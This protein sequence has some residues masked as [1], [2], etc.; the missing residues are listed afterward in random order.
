MN[1]FLRLELAGRSGDTILLNIDHIVRIHPSWPQGATIVTTDDASL[2]TS[3]S[4]DEIHK[5]M[6]ASN[7]RITVKWIGHVVDEIDPVYEAARADLLP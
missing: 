1:T 7:G 4:L 2:H 6:T 5:Q 3:A